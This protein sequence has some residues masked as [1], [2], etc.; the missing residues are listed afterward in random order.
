MIAPSV[1]ARAEP[2]ATSAA[3]AL[4]PAARRLVERL[5]Q[6]DDARLLRLRGVAG[7]GL[8]LVRG[9]AEDLPWAE[10]VLYL[11]Q[12]ESA[13]RLLLPTAIGPNLPS[14]VLE[15]AIA[16]RLEKD[17]ALLMSPWAVCFEP[18]LVIP[19]GNALPLRRD[20]LEA[21]H[22]ERVEERRS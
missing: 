2:L 15:R 1:S 8:V 6:L 3:L 20:A 13:P 5:L 21:W 7:H 11:G 4:G 18:P 12:D 19:S 16:R 14:A 10:G 22:A 9:A 17:A